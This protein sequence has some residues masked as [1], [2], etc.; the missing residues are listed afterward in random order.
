MERLT[1]PKRLVY[2]ENRVEDRT[3]WKDG[4][5]RKAS[6]SFS[7]TARFLQNLFLYAES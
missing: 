6:S 7:K 5:A 3:R 1:R 2:K 4:I